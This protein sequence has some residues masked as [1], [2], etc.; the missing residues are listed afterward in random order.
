MKMRKLIASISAVSMLGSMLGSM[1]FSVQAKTGNVYEDVISIG[2]FTADNIGAFSFL[3]EDAEKTNTVEA[4]WDHYL[5]L[6][7]KCVAG[8][9]FTMDLGDSVRRRLL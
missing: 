1:S 7:D 5:T 8:D 9:G 3:S 6:A 4:S 2:S